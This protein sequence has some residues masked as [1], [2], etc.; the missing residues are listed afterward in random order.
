MVLSQETSPYRTKSRGFGGKVG[1]SHIFG[2]RRFDALPASFPKGKESIFVYTTCTWTISGC[3]VNNSY[4]PAA[5]SA[6][7]G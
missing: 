2:V 6:L 1:F 7:G 3:S 5:W 4:D